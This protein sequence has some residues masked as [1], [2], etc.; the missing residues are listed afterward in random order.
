MLTPTQLSVL[1]LIPLEIVHAY[2]RQND[3]YFMSWLLVYTTALLYHFTRFSYP[4]EIRTRTN[5]YYADI[6]AAAFA[7]ILGSYDIWLYSTNSYWYY[8]IWFIHY[9]YPVWY[10]GCY[11]QRILMWSENEQTREKWHVVFH[12]VTHTS[13]QLHLLNF[14]RPLPNLLSA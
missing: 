3:N 7:Y 12:I 14:V 13:S 8:L 4:I 2:Y 9:G 10:I 1:T 6:A 11:F 5:F